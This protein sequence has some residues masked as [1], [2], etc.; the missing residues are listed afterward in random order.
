MAKVEEIIFS[1]HTIQRHLQVHHS[2]SCLCAS[3]HVLSAPPSAHQKLLFTIQNNLYFISSVMLALI[4]P[5][6][7]MFPQYFYICFIIEKKSCIFKISSL[8]DCEHLE[9][10]DQ[11]FLF[12][13]KEDLY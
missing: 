9:K 2:F 7:M 3:L 8:I 5:E 10:R 1:S 11:V 4:I 13:S 12:V 6:R